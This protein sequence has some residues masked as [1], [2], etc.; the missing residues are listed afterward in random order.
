MR[1]RAGFSLIE[2]LLALAL[3]GFAL[4]AASSLL[5]SLSS[6][7]SRETP[8][9]KVF[10][11]RCYNLKRMLREMVE[12]SAG[13]I[14]VKEWPAQ[15]DDPILCFPGQNLRLCSGRLYR[16]VRARSKHIFCRMGSTSRSC[17]IPKL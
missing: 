11:E 4:T 2:A 15:G 7:W 9:K 1:R 16:A 5:I 12:E 14:E 8:Q 3:G 13:A 6:S 10:E 17:G